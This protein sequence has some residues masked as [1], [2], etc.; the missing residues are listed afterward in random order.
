MFILLQ[1]K[2]LK[3]FKLNYPAHKKGQEED[4]IVF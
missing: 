2:I 4:W 3:L 1:N